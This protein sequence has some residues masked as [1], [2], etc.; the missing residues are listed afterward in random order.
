[1]FAEQGL[2]LSLILTILVLD[3]PASVPFSLWSLH[4]SQDAAEGRNP[5]SWWAAG[6]K[7]ICPSSGHLVT[8]ILYQ[9]QFTIAVEV[10]SASV[11]TPQCFSF[12][13]ATTIQITSLPSFALLTSRNPGNRLAPSHPPHC[14][15]RPPGAAVQLPQGTEGCGLFRENI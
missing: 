12:P 11:A 4:S 7:W 6:D 1:M 2:S 3:L 14:L 15:Y 10:R 5:V 8:F 13:C 9:I